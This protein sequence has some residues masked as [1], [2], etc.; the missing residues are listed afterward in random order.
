MKRKKALWWKV[1]GAGALLSL[2]IEV[3]QYVFP[4]GR[5]TDIDDWM[6]NTLGALVGVLLF[7]VGKSLYRIVKNNWR[8]GRP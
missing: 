3:C 7:Q 1:T 4:L 2:I 8:R 5:A 6:M